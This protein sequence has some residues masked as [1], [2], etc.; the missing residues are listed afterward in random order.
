MERL[1]VIGNV[2][3]DRTHYPDHRGGTRLGGAA[4]LVSLASGK[5]GRLAAPVCVLGNDLAHL[6]GTPGLNGLD[7]SAHRRA[8]G[9]SATFELMYDG[10]GELVAVRAG[11]GVAEGLTAHA[12]AHVDERPDG[13]YHVCCRHPLDVSAVLHRLTSHG[14]AFSVDFFLPSAGEMIRAAARW[15]PKA[16]AVFV[17]AAEYRLLN[18]VLDTACLPEVIVTDGPRAAQVRRFGRL[19]A[20]VL[21][22][23][24]SAREVTGAGDTLA[25]TFLALRSYGAAP[26]EALTGGVAAAAE[27]VSAPPLPIPAPRPV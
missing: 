1:A 20:S 8:D 4:L 15:L 14:A 19:T 22:P 21:P 9:P 10:E 5:A 3:R 2:S 23:P 7:W 16:T 25:G 27:Y 12:L 13:T 6:P 24:R 18:S 26:R 11:Y 17:N